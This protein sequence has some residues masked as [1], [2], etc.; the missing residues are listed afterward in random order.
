MITASLDL[1]RLKLRIS[2]VEDHPQVKFKVCF[3]SASLNIEAVVGVTHRPT[4]LAE[5]RKARRVALQYMSRSMLGMAELYELRSRG[6]A[7]LVEV[8]AKIT[9]REPGTKIH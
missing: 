5:W 3:Y 9:S 2:P 6:P 8:F 1:P 7:A 4:C